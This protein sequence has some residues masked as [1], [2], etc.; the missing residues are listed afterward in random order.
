MSISIKRKLMSVAAA[1]VCLL[2]LARVPAEAGECPKDHAAPA[3]KGPNGDPNMPK[4]VT[5]MIVA[6]TDLGR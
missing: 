1:T 2:A 5:D 6:A 3:G 4:G